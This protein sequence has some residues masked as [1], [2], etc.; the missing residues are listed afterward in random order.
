LIAPPGYNGSAHH[1]F[2]S[3][4]RRCHSLLVVAILC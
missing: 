2:D 1:R 4:T 3:G